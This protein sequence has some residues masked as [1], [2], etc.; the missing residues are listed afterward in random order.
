MSL[1]L[2][3]VTNAKTPNKE[4]VMLRADAKINLKKYALVD[5]TFDSEE[6]VSNE[7]RHVFFFPDLVVEK[8]DFIILY[9]GIGKYK[10]R[11]EMPSG[12]FVHRLY[13]ESSECV[14]ND[15]GNDQASLIEFKHIKSVKV[16][17]VEK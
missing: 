2:I 12:G 7:F 11:N 13:W 3:S 4:F 10:G 1:N 15:N 14:W 8:D 17:A 9:T 5:K 16:P 6:K